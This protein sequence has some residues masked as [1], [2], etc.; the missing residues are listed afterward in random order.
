M[1][2]Q[3]SGQHMTFVFNKFIYCIEIPSMS[4]GKH[5]LLLVLSSSLSSPSWTTELTVICYFSMN[6]G[7]YFGGIFVLK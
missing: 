6:Q 1:D 3:A 4:M 2:N 5:I 7:E